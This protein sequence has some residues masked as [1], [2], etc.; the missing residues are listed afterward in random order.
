MNTSEKRIYPASKAL[1][2][3]NGKFLA[4]HKS[5]VVTEDVL[6]L[7]GGKMEFGETAEKTLVREVFEETGLTVKPIRIVDT[8]ILVKEDFQIAG[9][10]YLC[11]II[12]GELSLSEEHDSYVWLNVESV[13]VERMHES[14]RIR[15]EKWDW[16]NIK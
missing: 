2:I 3:N 14:F 13:S 5:K 15:M 12:S 7:P 11:E 6:E 9:I 10:I 4:M 1:I 16:D 8:W